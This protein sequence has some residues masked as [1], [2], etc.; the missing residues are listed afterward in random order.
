MIS[1]DGGR[2]RAALPALGLLSVMLAFI[3]ASYLL[4]AADVG[5]PAP[6]LV[7]QELNGQTFD[8]A[9][10]RGKVVIVN[11][12]ATWCPPCRKEMPDLQ[13]LYDKYKD[14]GFVVL[15]ISDEGKEKV[16]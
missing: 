9:A 2:M 5:Q 16:A 8:L 14:Q 11:F 7:A 4:A 10:Q 12:W 15:S 1:K 6:A 13:A 3:P